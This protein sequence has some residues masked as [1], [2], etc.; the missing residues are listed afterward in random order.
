MP[1]RRRSIVI[2]A[3]INDIHSL[4]EYA[5]TNFWVFLCVPEHIDDT[6]LTPS[7]WVQAQQKIERLSRNG[8]GTG[9]KINISVT[10][11]INRL[12]TE[13]QDPLKIAPRF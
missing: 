4:S 5:T 3:T 8:E 1:V 13:R 12:N 10:K 6:A 11:V 2:T 9:L 7:T